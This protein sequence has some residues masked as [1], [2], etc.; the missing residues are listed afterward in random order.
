MASEERAGLELSRVRGRSR[1]SDTPSPPWTC[2]NPTG[3]CDPPN[4]KRR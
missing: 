1:F 4:E 2:S 3:G